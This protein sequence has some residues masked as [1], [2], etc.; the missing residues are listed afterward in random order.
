MNCEELR[1]E[2]VA[3]ALGI[4]EDP[5]RAEIAA[6]LARECPECVAG[7]RS[8]MTTVAA[9]SGAVK[10]VD[11][12]KRL[13]HRVVAMVTPEPKPAFVFLPWAVSALLAIVLVSVA[14]SGRNR[15][16]APDT[17][18][19]ARALTILN[20]P[21]TKDVTF[22]DP[23]ARGRVF[24]SPKGV[25][26]IAAHM[27]K[28]ETNRTF[29]L[30]ILP[31]SGKPVPAGTFRSEAVSDEAVYVYEGQTANAAA[32]AVTVEPEGG[33]PQPTTTPFIVS[34]L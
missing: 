21:A 28:L 3:W 2:Y 34:K 18:K 6:H 15:Q 26:L 31:S 14:I 19:L 9:M 7:V 13:R 29:E 10:D 25:V 1:S 17:T 32:V 27:P 30:W 20:D 16:P 8:A 22:G 33:S 24:V 4:A 5:A 12:P 11:P 23:A